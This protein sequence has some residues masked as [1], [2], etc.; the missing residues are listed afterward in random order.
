MSVEQQRHRTT[1]R[2]SIARTRVD[3]EAS[4]RVQL[5]GSCAFSLCA[6][7]TSLT[8]A[9]A[10]SSGSSSSGYLRPARKK[11]SDFA[12]KLAA[13]PIC[14]D[15]A[16]ETSAVAVTTATPAS[17]SPPPTGGTAPYAYPCLAAIGPLLHEREVRNSH[18]SQTVFNDLNLHHFTIDD[19][20]REALLKQRRQ[21][22]DGDCSLDAQSTPPSLHLHSLVQSFL[23]R[24]PPATMSDSGSS[25]DS[26]II[27]ADI[28]SSV[29]R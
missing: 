17:S 8:V 26:E 16:H 25:G 7:I 18:E 10:S 13:S 19:E 21:L 23:H 20:L 27:S 9:S 15:H 4:M 14:C 6:D 11:K 3:Q 24:P 29:V 5:T 22:A 1:D 28:T 2:Y 12:A